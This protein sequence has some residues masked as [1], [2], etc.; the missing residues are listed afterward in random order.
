[1]EKSQR[2]KDKAGKVRKEREKRERERVR[3][4]ERKRIFLALKEGNS[5]I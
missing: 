1:M 4:G 5:I 3:E 2:R